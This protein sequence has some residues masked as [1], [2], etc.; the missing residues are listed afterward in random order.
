[1]LSVVESVDQVDDM[2]P[3]G[4]IV[5]QGERVGGGASL[6]SILNI[7]HMMHILHILNIWFTQATSYEGKSFKIHS[8]RLRNIC[9]C[10][11]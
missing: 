11:F 2:L 4:P 7:I 10:Y 1:M 5:V 8:I 6:S 9:L 3:A